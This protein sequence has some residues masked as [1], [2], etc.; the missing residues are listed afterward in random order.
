MCGVFLST[1][2]AGQLGFVFMFVSVWTSGET[3]ATAEQKQELYLLRLDYTAEEMV[4]CTLHLLFDD[5]KTHWKNVLLSFCGRFLT[6]NHPCEP[7]LLAFPPTGGPLPWL[8][9][10]PSP[11]LTKGQFGSRA[12]PVWSLHLKKSW[13]PL[14]LCFKKPRLAL[15]RGYVGSTEA[16]NQQPQVRTKPAATATFQ[17]WRQGH[18][19]WGPGPSSA[20]LTDTQM[21]CP[22]QP[23]SKLQSCGYFKFGESVFHETT[24]SGVSRI[25]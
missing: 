11:A 9:P 19:G 3:G 14:P 7:C 1:T 13:R 8:W 16:T 4:T 22:R 5:R 17:P 24:G 25:Y 2:L 23:L 18:L 6:S 10:V 20:A 15:G 12:A 21:N